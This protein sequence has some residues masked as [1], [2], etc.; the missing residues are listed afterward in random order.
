M[1]QGAHRGCTNLFTRALSVSTHQTINDNK[2]TFGPDERDNNPDEDI[3]ILVCHQKFIIFVLKQPIK[4]RKT[5]HL[6]PG[7][8]GP[9]YRESSSVASSLR[10][11]AAR[12]MKSGNF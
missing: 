3:D 4:I 12:G 11:P 10:R 9:T 5:F 6:A 8:G 2:N 7:A 1:P